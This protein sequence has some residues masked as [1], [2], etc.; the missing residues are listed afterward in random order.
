MGMMTSSH[1]TMQ[2]QQSVSKMPLKYK[3]TVL[4]V[5]NALILTKEEEKREFCFTWKK[6]SQLIHR[7][8]GLQSWSAR[9]LEEKCLDIQSGWE[10]GSP[11]LFHTTGN[12]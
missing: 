10:K 11:G 12:R 2:G 4:V 9:E 6:H 5:K 3:S 1:S 8:L 7:P